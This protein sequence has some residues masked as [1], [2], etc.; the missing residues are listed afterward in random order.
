MAADY[1]LCSHSAASFLNLEPEAIPVAYPLFLAKLLIR[2][3]L[4]RA[5]PSVQRWTD[6]GAAFLRYY[7]DTVLA[8]PIEEVH[9]AADLMELNG[10]DAI[11]L[12]LGSPRFDLV[13]S[14]ST[15][16]PADR[17]GWPPA[18]GL[19]ELREAIAQMLR[20][21][22]QLAVS[23]ADEVLVTHGAAGAVSVALDTF[24]NPGD[25]V[26]ILE[27]ASPLYILALRSRQV[28]MRW[29]AT[30]IDNGRLRFRLDHL[31]KAMRRARLLVINSPANPTG[32]IIAPEDLEQIAWWA[33]RR[34]ALVLSDEVFARYQYEGTPASIGALPKARRRTLTVGSVSKSHA[35]A[36]ARVGWLAG[37]RHLIRPCLLLQTLHT[38]FVPVLSQQIALAALRLGSDAWE[39][40]RSEFASRR[41]YAYERLQSMGLKPAWPAGAYFFWVP[42]NELAASGQAFAQE[43]L[44]VKRMLVSPGDLFGPSG[45]GFIR[46]SYATDEGR[47]REGLNRLA[48]F[49]RCPRSVPVRE[50]VRAA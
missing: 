18:A 8:A 41:R 27:P 1:P 35:L 45:S 50:A 26:V 29:L 40:I 46:I 42:V 9:A 12:A 39:P 14:G 7:S 43:L 24:V 2:S 37:Y 21:D 20:V 44:K 38:P 34:D 22:H 47:L 5:F 49:L 15:K 33:E 10:P 25:R 13:P 6:G 17:R 19:P 48:D 36:S 32:G 4:A 3:G 30:W 23:P 28:R 31:A 16:L 11:D